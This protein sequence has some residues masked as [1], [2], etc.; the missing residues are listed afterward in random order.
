MSL[1]V[2]ESK[3][4]LK[5]YGDLSKGHQG[6]LGYIAS[7][8]FWDNL[9]IKINNDSTDYNLLNKVLRKQKTMSL[10]QEEATFCGKGQDS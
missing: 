4:I 1:I 5:E 9:N 3:Q 8:Q 7:D 10:Y 6:Q 2:L